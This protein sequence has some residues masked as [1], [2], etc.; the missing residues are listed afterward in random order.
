MALAVLVVGLW[1]GWLLV[2]RCGWRLG[3]LILA[4]PVGWPVL[5]ESAGSTFR[6]DPLQILLGLLLLWIWHQR[7]RGRSL[8]AAPAA[9]F[10]LA[11]VQVFAVLNHEPFALLILPVLAIAALGVRRDWSRAL[12]ATSPGLLAFLLAVWK[13]GTT[14]QVACLRDDLQRLGLLGPTEMP[15]SSITELALSRPSFF[16]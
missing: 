1:L 13:K 12:M 8:R 5:L 6:K 15:G 4:A 16:T 14:S 2:R 11:V 10:L 9:W 3:L 7:V